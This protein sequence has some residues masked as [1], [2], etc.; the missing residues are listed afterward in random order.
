MNTPT[1]D[2]NQTTELPVTEITWSKLQQ[3]QESDRAAA[4]GT[5]KED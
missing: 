2:N 3:L 4:L 1:D 5:M